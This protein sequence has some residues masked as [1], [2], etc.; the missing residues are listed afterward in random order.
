MSAISFNAPYAPQPVAPAQHDAQ[1]AAFLGR[2]AETKKTSGENANMSSDHSGQGARDRTGTGGTHLAALLERGRVAMPPVG[3]SP[4]SVVEA[5]TKNKVPDAFL[6]QQAKIRAESKALQEAQDAERAAERAAAAAEA[7][8][9]AQ[10]PEV[11]L[12]NPLPTAPIL[13]SDDA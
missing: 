3:A 7:A 12:P 11:D 6:D 13:Q 5:Q 9:E 10:E 1:N 4:K 2:V 8:A